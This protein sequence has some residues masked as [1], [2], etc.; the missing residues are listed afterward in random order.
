MFYGFTSQNTVA[1]ES[2]VNFLNIKSDGVCPSKTKLTNKIT[3]RYCLHTSFVNT[4]QFGGV[5]F[6]D[7]ISI[8]TSFKIINTAQNTNL[9]EDK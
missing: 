6:A 8:V 4:V 7:M 2:D 3:V 5:V 9:L 1:L